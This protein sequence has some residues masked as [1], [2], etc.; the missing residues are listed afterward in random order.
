VDPSAPTEV[1]SP[2]QPPPPPV[3][4]LAPPPQPPAGSRWPPIGAVVAAIALVG[5]LVVIVLAVAGVPPFTAS[6]TSPSPAPT[7]TATA[8]PSAT[9]SA[10]PTPSATATS[11][12]TPL[13]S[14]EI[15]SALAAI[16]RR[17]T[18]IRELSATTSLPGKLVTT[19]EASKIL[20]DDFHEANPAQLIDDTTAP[21]RALGLLTPEQDLGKLFDRFLSTQVL[22]FYRD[23]DKS[24]YI[25]S[26]QGFGPLERFTASHEYTH[27]LQDQ[28]F[29]LKK[30]SPDA[31]DQGDRQLARTALIEGDATL[32]MT[33]WATTDLSADEI[34]QLLQQL[35]DPESEQVLAEM[36]PIVRQ[37]QEFPYSDGLRFV[38]RF[39]TSGGWSAVDAVWKN[40]PDT[41]EQVLHP[42]KY[43]SDEQPVPVALKPAV[44]TSLG[45]GWTLALEDTAGELVTKIWLDLA[46]DNEAAVAAAAGWGGDRIGYYKGPN[47]AWGVAWVTEW[48]SAP[49][50]RQFALAAEGIVLRLGHA[51]VYAN[52]GTGVGVFVASDASLVPTLGTA[53]GFTPD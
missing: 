7:S 4:P 52:G 39:W 30:I 28:H 10:A 9:A 1:I 11:S 38:Q 20:V 16:E 15:E 33:Q 37:T 24:L 19:P 31:F 34:A 26:D 47:G 13:G 51:A 32:A 3:A 36:P 23:T 17:M 6:G 18:Q 29:D 21:Y 25:V 8:L 50:A 42:E 12:P 46:G 48:D 27:A 53:S 41:V 2:P 5:A 14:A 45:S 22:G 43:T 44:L 49:E 40:P 35:E